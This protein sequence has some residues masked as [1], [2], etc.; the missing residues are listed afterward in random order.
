MQ[1]YH[2]SPDGDAWKLTSENGHD[3]IQ[4]FTNKLDAIAACAKFMED[5]TGSLK[6][7]QADGTIE[8]ER[9]YPRSSDPVA[10]KG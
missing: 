6:I 10:S 4:S 1:N 8:E 9:T 7:H 3:Q 5:R 2:L